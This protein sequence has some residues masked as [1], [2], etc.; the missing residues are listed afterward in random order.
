VEPSEVV[1]A[2]ATHPAVATCTVLVCR[3]DSADVSL[4]AYIVNS[5]PSP[6]SIGE[7]ATAP[8]G[9]VPDASVL[10]SVL[11]IWRNLL[12]T[13]GLGEALRFTVR[14]AADVPG[15]VE[16]LLAADAHQRIDLRNS[17]PVVARATGEFAL[18]VPPVMVALWCRPLGCE[19]VNVCDNFFMLGG[20]SLLA[21][22][23]VTRARDF[24]PGLRVSM[25]SLIQLSAA[26][27]ARSAMNNEVNC[28]S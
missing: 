24:L 8:A 27:A 26:S 11:R 15:G 25:Y 21:I 10:A 28:G 22:R 7:P 13:P 16:K 19:H 2:I 18:P 6:P 1:A 5:G 12:N 17:L 20:G 14:D 4:V 23:M 3:I 9:K